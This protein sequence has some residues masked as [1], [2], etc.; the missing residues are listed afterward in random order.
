M[1]EVLSQAI[2]SVLTLFLI[3]AIGYSLARFKLVSSAVREIFPIFVVRVTLPLFLVSE[4]VKTF[5]R[6]ELAS[7]LKW[8][9]LGLLTV[10]V[11]FAVAYLL[12]L[13][14]KPQGRRRGIFLA[15]F[16][17]SN[18]MYIGIPINLSLFGDQALGPAMSYF[19]ANAIFFWTAGN[20]F[21]SLDGQI[22]RVPFISFET[23]KRLL[24]PPMLGF[25]AGV[26]LVVLGIQPPKFFMSATSAI[27][28]MNTPLAIMFIGLG[29]YGLSL[30]SLKPYKEIAVVLGGRFIVCPAITLSFCLLADAP[31]ITSQVFTTQSSLPVLA[32]ASIMAGYY[33]SDS[34]YAN[35]LVSLSTVLSLLTIPLI[36]I[37]M[38]TL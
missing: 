8:V 32:A 3:G 25:I 37:L 31:I 16:S 6:D 38:A 14:I 15:A 23:V 26:I 30:A 35:I 5:T 1:P 18:T 11:T 24:P 7:M 10:F 22:G 13:L 20:Y 17:A 19:L 9:G 21:M 2:D 12:S 36:R 34:N 27:G 28:A 33:K 29:F 4:T